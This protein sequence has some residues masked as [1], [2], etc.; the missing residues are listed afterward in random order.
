MGPRTL[1]RDSTLLPLFGIWL[2]NMAQTVLFLFHHQ[3]V[4][5]T[6]GYQ[7]CPSAGLVWVL[8]LLAFK[9]FTSC[10]SASC[11]SR[12]A[13]RSPC[14]WHQQRHGQIS[15]RRNTANGNLH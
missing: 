9:L 12:S 15:E 8:A 1:F 5:L 14:L 4:L 13:P 10:C 7:I 3:P 6:I 11:R 2:L